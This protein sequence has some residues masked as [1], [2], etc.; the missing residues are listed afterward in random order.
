[1]AESAFRG[2]IGFLDSIGIYDVIL[3]FVLV[4]TI[5]FAILEKTRIL[6]SEEIDKVKYT[7]KPLNALVA[8]VIAFF[9]VG[10]GELVGILT[11]VSSQAVILL[12]VSILFLLLVG[13]FWQEKDQ[14]VF[15]EGAYNKLFMVIM[16]IGIVLIFLNAIKTKSGRSWLDFGWN[17]LTRNWNNDAV[18]A[19]IFLI[20]IILFMYFVLRE[21]RKKEEKKKE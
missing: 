5:T 1:M 15:L 12:M 7:K 14:G 6:G 13:S 18:S 10:S 16:F 8:F 2:M 19:I 4:F 9:V 20:V 17:W 3:P 21:P 11:T